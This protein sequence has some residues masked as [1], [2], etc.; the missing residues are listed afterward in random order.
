MLV[1]GNPGGGGDAY[2]SRTHEDSVLYPLLTALKFASADEVLP[3]FEAVNEAF[4][5]LVARWNLWRILSPT[6]DAAAVRLDDVGYINMVPYRT[7]GDR[8]PPVGVVE[9]AWRLV[10]SE[11]LSTLNPGTLICLGRKAGK[12]LDRCHDGR[13]RVWCVP[14]TIGDSYISTDAEAVLASIR[15]SHDLQ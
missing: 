12:M 3:A 1:G 11:L 14:R 10:T 15:A 13:A 9:N 7:R 5:P 8:P 6:L 4:P 2:R